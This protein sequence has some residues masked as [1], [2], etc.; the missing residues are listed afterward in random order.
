MTA[1][2]LKLW[3]RFEVTVHGVTHSGG[4]TTTASTISVG[5]DNIVD[6]TVL[7]DASAEKVLD[8]ADFDSGTFTFIW[9]ENE[10]ASQTVDVQI[11]VSAGIGDDYIVFTIPAG[12]RL[13][14][15]DGTAPLKGT[16]DL[17]NGTAA[18]EIGEIWAL[19]SGV[20]TP[21]RVVATTTDAGA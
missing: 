12:Q 20:N 8:I 3:Q 11:T 16:I 10:H 21:L 17:L 18:K 15:P 19:A 5:S 14:F 6:K 7:I 13:V 4:S 9:L 1:I 2:N